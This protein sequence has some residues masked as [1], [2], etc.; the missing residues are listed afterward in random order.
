MAKTCTFT[1]TDGTEIPITVYDSEEVC[2]S[3]NLYLT[4]T[5]SA[6]E[7][8]ADGWIKLGDITDTGATL[9]RFTNNNDETYA[10]L[11]GVYYTATINQSD[12][13]TIHVYTPEKSDGTDHTGTF[14]VKSGTTYEG[15]VIADEDY[16]AGTLSVTKV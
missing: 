10:I 9:G 5:D 14:K 7:Q 15:E 8:V 16:E 12:N 13:Q 3:P 1:K 11:D 4:F 2:P 6:G